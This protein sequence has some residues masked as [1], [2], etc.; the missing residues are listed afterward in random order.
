[1]ALSA[2][3]A[4]LAVAVALVGVAIALQRRP[5]VPAAVAGADVGAALEILR[6]SVED[7]RVANA[8]LMGELRGEVQRAL[9]ATE[10]SLV[11][12]T[13]ATQRTLTDLSRQ[14]G[15]LGE[16]S[17]RIGDLAKDIRSEEHTSELQSPYD[18]VC[19]L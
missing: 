14:L 4:G 6:R 5:Q 3:L 17:V 1:M 8:A 18:L 2:G 7:T 10:Q 15:T 9:G 19:R 16:Q 12:Q 11:T 13:T